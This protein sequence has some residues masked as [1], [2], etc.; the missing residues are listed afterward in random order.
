MAEYNLGT[1]RG[2][3][4]LDADQVQSGIQGAQGSLQ[5]ML[6]E[7][8]GSSG[9][10]QNVAG[11]LDTLG[12][13]IVSVFG[14]V[15]KVV[16]AA[17][18]GMATVS[19]WGGLN[20]VLDT[21][22]ARVQMQRMGVAT[23]DVD[24]LLG[25]VDKTFQGTPFANPDGF[26]ISSQLFASGVA[27]EGIPGILGDIAD[28]AAHGNVPIDQM[29]SLFVRVAAQGKVTG[30]E[31][32]RLT[33]MNIP[34]TQLADAM[35]VTVAELREMTS[36]GEVTADTFFEGIAGVEMFEGAAKAAGDTTRGAFSNV[37]TAL[38][39]LG[40]KFLS[41]LFG[42]NGFAV[43]SMKSLREAIR[44]LGPVAA[45]MGEAFAAWLIPAIE[46]LSNWLSTRLVPAFQRVASMVEAGIAFYKENEEAIKRIL[47]AVGPAAAGLAAFATSVHLIR[48]AWQLLQAATPI[49]LLLLIA[50]AL[51]YAWQNSE[52]FREIV[53]GAFEA[54]KKVLEPVFEL[55]TGGSEKIEGAKSAVG[56]LAK[57][58][59]DVLGA[60]ISW[61]RDL[62]DTLSPRFEAIGESFSG[63]M[64]TLRPVAQWLGENLPKA[65][66]ALW[67]VAKPILGF[68]IETI[69]GALKLA[70]DGIVQVFQGA[71][72]IIE[73]ILNVFAGL[74]TGN[75]SRLWEGIKQIF[76]GVWNALVGLVKVWLA[77]SFL[78]LFSAPLKIIANLWRGTWNGVR[79]FFVNI[80]NAIKNF[81]F[82]GMKES[83]SRVT[84]VLGAIRN[85][86]SGVWR[87]I[88][89]FITGVIRGI[90]NFVRNAFNNMRLIVGTILS[91]LRAN[92]VRIFN[93]IRSSIYNAAQRA[94]TLVIGAFR[95][96]VNGVATWIRTL[97]SKARRLPGDILRAIGNLGRLLWNAGKSIIQGLIGGIWSMASSVKNAVSGVLEKARNLLPWSPAKEGPFSGKGWTLYSGKS[98]I[99]ALAQGIQSQ[100]GQAMKAALGVA[101]SVS[102]VL[103]N[104][105]TLDM[106]GSMSSAPFGAPTM[107]RVAIS[108]QQTPDTARGGFTQEVRIDKIEARDPY[109]A[110]RIAD[111]ELGW[112]FRTGTLA[113][114]G[115]N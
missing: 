61:F 57:F 82:R 35:G 89:S 13:K 53:T 43:Q 104:P 88:N 55:F 64:D 95:G 32:N 12:G 3:I 27:L 100:E 41:P 71:V 31:L 101:K 50:S 44:S 103:T 107:P 80:F 93:L 28:L 5:G 106:V 52:K 48:R 72:S 113:H 92:A 22:D 49:G 47:D 36:A 81:L 62:W 75:W 56:G 16:G 78:K 24:K 29:G 54:V 23:E 94:R 18:A 17:I 97:L 25:D 83:Q 115:G 4:E 51:V 86:F 66:Q 42:E 11:S 38:A 77:G 37:R 59:R 39:L 6:S 26:N 91:N 46:R 20:R 87:A 102:G 110:A 14:T 111:E 109:E 105:M 60:A 58:F 21:E 96:L 15:S 112:E 76:S 114:R 108:G 63:I 98:I 79:S 90:V 70:I 85:V 73:G 8:E 84:T 65:F 99:D 1:A 9:V 40:D 69:G 2:R 67:T 30:Q 33:D 45:A 7:L 34:L 74:F 19:L 10:F 68:L